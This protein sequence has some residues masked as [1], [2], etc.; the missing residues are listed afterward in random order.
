MRL[1]ALSDIKVEAQAD[2]DGLQVQRGA[3]EE[4]V[5]M[6]RPGSI[7]RDLLEERARVVLG[8]RYENESSVF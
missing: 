8:L 7:D 4:D 6:L 1:S 3:I 5:V 2:L